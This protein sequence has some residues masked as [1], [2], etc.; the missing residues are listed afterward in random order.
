MTG[1][2]RLMLHTVALSILL[3]GTFILRAA[4]ADMPPVIEER[5]EAMKSLGGHMKAINESLESGNPDGAIVAQHAAEIET[6]A[7][8][9][10]D[11]FPEGTSLEDVDGKVGAKPEIWSDWAGFEQAA[12]ALGTQA[13]ALAAA[14]GTGDADAMGVQFKLV[15]ESCGGCHS[16]FRQKVE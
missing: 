6:I 9:I 1:R 7:A 14:A 13:A 10:P 16:K 3:T 11:L 8:A 5:Q 4:D 12:M 15:G 2:N